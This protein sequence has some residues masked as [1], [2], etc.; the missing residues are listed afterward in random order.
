MGARLGTLAISLVLSVEVLS[1]GCSSSPEAAAPPSKPDAS[2]VGDASTGGSSSGSG[3]KGG[4]SAG[5]AGTSGA[6][7]TGG[8]TNGGSGGASTAGG[9]G[10]TNG[11]GTD[12]GKPDPTHADCDKNGSAETQLGTTQNC[13]SCG[14]VCKATNGNAAC[15]AGKCTVGS[16]FSGFD[17]CDNDPTNGCEASLKDSIDTCGSCTK[18]CR[19]D[20]DGG[21]QTGVSCVQ[22]VCVITSCPAGYDNC[23]NNAADGCETPLNT[24]TDC[25][26]CGN[27]CAVA[28]GTPTCKAGVCQVACSDGTT[29]CTKD[30]RVCGVGWGD[31]DGAGS[32]GCETATNTLGSCGA[33]DL[34]CDYANAKETC[35]LKAGAYVCTFQG[36]SNG[37]ADCNKDAPPVGTGTNSYVGNSCETS[38]SGTPQQSTGP[39]SNCGACGTTCNAA[40][41]TNICQDNGGGAYSCGTSG[42]IPGSGLFD[43]PSKPGQDCL[44]ALVSDGYDSC[45][46]SGV[47]AATIAVAQGGAAVTRVANTADGKP[48]WYK[49][50]LAGRNSGP[51]NRWTD[52]VTINIFQGSTASSGGYRFRVFEGSNCPADATGATSAQSDRVTCQSAQTGIT[53]TPSFDTLQW[54][55]PCNV[56]KAVP[57]PSHGSTAVPAIVG[58]NANTTTAPEAFWVEVLPAVPGT[59]ETYKLSVSWTD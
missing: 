58:C 21:S 4:S 8:A 25:G 10:G 19:A 51:D 36:C 13:A 54:T 20:G 16:C 44:C 2:V 5:G 23:N 31:C 50:S 46:L 40:G 22:G 14:D 39:I 32:N 34:P 43:D 29:N 27:P 15:V 56:S 17:D 28:N 38:I 3:G 26:V 53:A 35:E 12:A 9:A 42:C 55:D 6:P 41:S 7:N 24:L 33:C 47:S 30:K 57:T 48:D 11:G 52:V 1:A 37:Y 59:C 49:F 45:P 18:S